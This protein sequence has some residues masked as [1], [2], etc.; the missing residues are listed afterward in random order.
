MGLYISGVNMPKERKITLTIFPDG[1]VYENHGDRLWGHGK[2]CIPWKAV[3][4]Q[5]HGRLIE[6]RAILDNIQD[7]GDDYTGYELN[8]MIDD[9]P[10][11]IPAE[12]ASV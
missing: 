10:T 12:E 5:P 1:R 8:R 11:V 4:V 6:A 2:D 3:S 7:N 9:V